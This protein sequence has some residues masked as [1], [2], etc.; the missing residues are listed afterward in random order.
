MH[1]GA[2]GAQWANGGPQKAQPGP[3]ELPSLLLLPLA[4]G[5]QGGFSAS[6]DPGSELYRTTP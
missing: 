3:S 6:G 1:Y 5:N 2:W 4:L